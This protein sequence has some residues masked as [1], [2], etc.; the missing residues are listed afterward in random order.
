MVQQ[1]IRTLRP[2]IGNASLLMLL[3]TMQY[4]PVEMHTIIFPPLTLTVVALLDADPD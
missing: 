4:L 3:L 2:T 1:V